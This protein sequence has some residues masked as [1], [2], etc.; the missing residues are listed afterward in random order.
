MS[1]DAGGMETSRKVRRGGDTNGVVCK[2]RDKKGSSGERRHSNKH[3]EEVEEARE[4]ATGRPQGRL[5]N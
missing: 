5:Q 2:S 1:E 4:Q 3:T